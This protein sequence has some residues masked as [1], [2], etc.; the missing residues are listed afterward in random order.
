LLPVGH[1]K[2]IENLSQIRNQL[3]HRISN[4]NFTFA[5]YFNAKEKKVSGN[6][7]T[8]LGDLWAF[9][10]EIA[11]VEYSHEP[12]ARQVMRFNVPPEVK[13]GRGPSRTDI[14]LAE[15]KVTILWSAL[16]VLEAMSICNLFGPQTWKFVMKC[17]DQRECEEWVHALFER[18][19]VEDK[20]LPEK[21]AQKFERIPGVRITRDSDGQ[22]ILESL[23]AGLYAWRLKVLQE[24]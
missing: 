7:R 11:G 24:L 14:L 2:F 18:A 5:E 21:T 8:A 20:D 19:K 12:L 13:K 15:P 23:A 10:V 6:Q 1:I 22:P 4:A 3:A 16:A 17:D 9:G